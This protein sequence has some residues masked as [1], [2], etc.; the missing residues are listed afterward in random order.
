MHTWII[1]VFMSCKIM[2]LER[3]ERRFQYLEDRQ[4]RSYQIRRLVSGTIGNL[5]A[6]KETNSLLEFLQEK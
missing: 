3:I 1:N 6:R 4:K 2:R 5:E